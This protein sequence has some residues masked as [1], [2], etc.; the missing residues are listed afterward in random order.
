M[1]ASQR[2]AAFPTP[3]FGVSGRL[4]LPVDGGLGNIAQR[5][6]CCLFL[7][8]RVLQERDGVLKAK[9]VGPRLRVP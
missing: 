1:N 3:R 6:V 8:E 9:L 7:L 4:G 5:F 2:N